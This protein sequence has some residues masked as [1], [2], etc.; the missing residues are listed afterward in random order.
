MAKKNKVKFGLKNVHYAPI[1]QDDDGNVTFATP[2]AIPGAVSMSLTAQGDTDEYYADNMLYYVSTTN[3]GY[4]G[5]LEMTVIPD[6]FR[7]DIFND[8]V[9][10]TD[11][12]QIENANVEPNP[13][14]LLYEVNGDKNGF[15]RLLY[16]C[17]C[18]RPAESSSTTTT[19]KTPNTESMTITA[20]PLA[21]G[22]VKAHTIADTPDTVFNS[23]FDK[24]WEPSK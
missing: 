12:V 24:V 10:S 22:R 23:W 5:E 7:T 19:S 20:S 8:T 3:N 13:F 14:V 21:D 16:Y 15:R 1:T 17:T 9:D 4:Q 18:T 11:K 2:K 6:E